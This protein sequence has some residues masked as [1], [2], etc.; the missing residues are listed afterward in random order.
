MSDGRYR[1]AKSAFEKP[2]LRS[3]VHCIGVRTPSRSP[4]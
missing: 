1:R 3:G 2:P 4:R